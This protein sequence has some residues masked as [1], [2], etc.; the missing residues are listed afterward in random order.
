MVNGAQ[1]KFIFNI[2]Q[3]TRPRNAICTITIKSDVCAAFAHNVE[4]SEANNYRAAL[5][6]NLCEAASEIIGGE[7]RRCG[8]L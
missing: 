2:Y 5:N 7:F 4:R 3:S 1:V 8:A 6:C